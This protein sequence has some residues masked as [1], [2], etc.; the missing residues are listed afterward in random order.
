MNHASEAR[1]S[2][3]AA[4]GA[5]PPELPLDRISIAADRIER[6][7]CLV[8]N[9]TCRFN[10]GPNPT[11]TLDDESRPYGHAPNMARMFDNLDRLDAAVQQLGS[12]G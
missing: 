9:F 3:L 11:A 5:K 1:G 4:A 10:G 8:E 7:A 12:I 6:L 2:I